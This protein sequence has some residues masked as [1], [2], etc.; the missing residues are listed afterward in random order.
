MGDVRT[1]VHMLDHIIKGSRRTGHLESYIEALDTEFLHRSF[2]C[3]AFGAIDSKR[4]THLLR[5]LKTQRVDIR[6]DD[7]LGTGVAAYTCSH[8][9]DESCTC[10]EHIFAKQRE[11]KGCMC[12]VA[13]RIHDRREV[14]GNLRTQLDDVRLRNRDVLCKTTVFAHDTYGNRVLADMSHASTA[15]TAVSADDMSLGCDAF[16]HLEVTHT[17]A[18]FG[19][20][21]YELMT[22]RIRRFAVGLRPRVPFIH[23]QIGTAYCGLDHLDEHIVHPYFRHRHIFHPDAR[24]GIFFN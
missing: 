12:G 22:H 10:D 4:C 3:L 2:D 15:V 9:S 21:T 7:M 1:F 11:S 20:D 17:S 8:R 14:I 19:Y 24:F 16:A 5:Y 13:E 6:H 23:M 18:Y